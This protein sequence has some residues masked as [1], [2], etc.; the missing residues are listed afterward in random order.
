MRCF[1]AAFSIG[2]AAQIACAQIANAQVRIKDITLKRGN[3]EHVLVG[4]GLVVGLN[5]SGDSMRNSVFTQQSMRTMLQRL[6]VGVAASELRTRNIAAVIVSAE[7]DPGRAAGSRIDVVTASL[8]DAK[9]LMG[10]TLIATP[11][12]GGDGKVYGI[13]QGQVVVSGFQGAGKGETLTQGVPT[14]GRIAN[15]AVIN[16]KIGESFVAR[17]VLTLELINPDAA[18]II[19]V[20]DRINRHSLRRYRMRVARERSEQTVALQVPKGVSAA[21][22]LAEIGALMVTPDI[23]AR[24]VINPR[25]GTVVM[26]RNVRISRV[27]VTHGSLTVRVTEN[28]VV[29]QPQPFSNGKTVTTPG[30]EVTASEAGGKFTALGGDL[31]T[32]IRGLNRVG[33]KP[34]GIIAVLQAMKSAGAIQAELIVQ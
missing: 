2:L 15:G 29:S 34:S 16:R 32:L 4:Y 11:L 6:G 27:A 23:A 33:V 19:A 28:P 10:G 3:R 22:L 13:A 9:S 25:T 8:G 21:R 1:V 12:F 24:I 20:V 31:Q 18:T 7:V 17:R 26:N 14:S 5:G 30:T